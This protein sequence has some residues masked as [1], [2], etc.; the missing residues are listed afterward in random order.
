[1]IPVFSY[2][3][4]AGQQRSAAALRKIIAHGTWQRHNKQTLRSSVSP[5]QGHRMP[6]VKSR[7]TAEADS[8]AESAPP[9]PV[10]RWGGVN[11]LR[12][13]RADFLAFAHALHQKY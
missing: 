3:H 7:F 9:G 2:W 8:M 4:V 11:L 12:A 1:M 13:I 5:S 6:N 10:G